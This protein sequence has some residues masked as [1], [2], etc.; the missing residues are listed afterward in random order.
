MS[1]PGTELD[2]RQCIYSAPEP[3]EI[4]MDDNDQ[5]QDGNVPTWWIVKYVLFMTMDGTKVPFNGIIKK[6]INIGCCCL[7]EPMTV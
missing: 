3:E 5:F 4:I 7:M 1:Q 2:K 6:K